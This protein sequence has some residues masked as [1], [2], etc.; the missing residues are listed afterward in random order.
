MTRDRDSLTA[1]PAPAARIHARP[2]AEARVAAA[3]GVRSVALTN[4][5]EGLLYVPNGYAAERPSALLVELHG[6]GS[7]AQRSLDRVVP[8]ADE[9]GTIVFA[10]Q[11]VAPTWD[12]IAGGYGPDVA[13][14]DA[15]LA[16]IFSH[17]NVDPRH[18]A[19]GGFS[20]GASYALSLG[21]DNGDLFT[22]II[23]FSPGFADPSGLAGEPRLFVSHGTQDNILP[24]D[25]SSRFVVPLLRQIG[26][27]VHYMEFEGAHTVPEHILRE[28]YRWWSGAAP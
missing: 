25:Q 2:G 6:A 8:L 18:I 28:S 3:A 10:P 1:D 15:A 26:Y 21:I 7:T 23:A 9:F 4:G 13:A 22:H 12:L 19:V 20:D 24:I 14:I 17:Y 5:R 27:D 11:S 16:D